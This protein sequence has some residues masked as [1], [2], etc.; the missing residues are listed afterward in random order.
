VQPS[1]ADQPRI[2]VNDEILPRKWTAKM[3]HVKHFRFNFA[4]RVGLAMERVV[5]AGFLLG[6]KP[7]S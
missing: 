1:P 5:S 2:E 6:R 4:L 3:F 7:A